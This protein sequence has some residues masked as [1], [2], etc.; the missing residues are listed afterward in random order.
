MKKFL[1][2][3]LLLSVFTVLYQQS[4]EVQN[5]Y[6]TCLALAVFMFCM[7]RLSSKIPSKDKDNDV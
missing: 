1:L 5:L 7:M 6:V 4:L 2:P 3:I